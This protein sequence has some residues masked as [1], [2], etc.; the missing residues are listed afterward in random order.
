MVWGAHCTN[1]AQLELELAI[2]VQHYY[3][4]HEWLAG[5]LA[6]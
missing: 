6:L 3:S 2:Q 4:L 1:K 5:V